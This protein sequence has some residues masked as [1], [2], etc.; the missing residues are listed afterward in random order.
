[1][2]IWGWGIYR[3]GWIQEMGKIWDGLWVWDGLGMDL[4]HRI[5][6]LLRL[7]KTC[8]IIES[9]RNLTILPQLQQQIGRAHV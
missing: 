8:K 5:I 4:H 9:N 7:E 6:E 2:G 1:M 3:V